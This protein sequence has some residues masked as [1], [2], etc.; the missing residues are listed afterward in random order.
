MSDAT[1]SSN[2]RRVL[3]DQFG[4]TYLLMLEADRTDAAIMQC[5]AELR[6][7]EDDIEEE[8]RDPDRSEYLYIV[9]ERS[10]PT[11]A[12]LVERDGP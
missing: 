7:Y 6:V 11:A 10:R 3:K 5:L 4:A 12:Y 9:G 2:L 1:P 8:L